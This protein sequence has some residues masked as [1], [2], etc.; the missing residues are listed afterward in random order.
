MDQ[1]KKVS[2]CQFNRLC[3]WINFTYD[4]TVE[5]MNEVNDLFEIRSSFFRILLPIILVFGV[6]I[7]IAMIFMAQR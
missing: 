3:K 5:E 4:G 1:T 2:I 6:L 7:A